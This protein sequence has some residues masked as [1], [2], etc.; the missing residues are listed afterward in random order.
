MHVVIVDGDV[1][2]PPT[3]GKRL[4]TLHLMLRLAERHHII[5]I[6]RRQETTGGVGPAIEFL[7]DHHIEPILVDDPLPR[8]KG[9]LFYGRLAA[10]VASAWPYSVASHQSTRVRAAVAAYA[11]AHQVD[12]WQF[13]WSAYLPALSRAMAAPRL[14]IAHNV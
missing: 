11:A 10:N 1:S 5:Y 8:K 6:G 9:L 13:E 3:S 12:L 4:R 14:L 2:Y 7:R